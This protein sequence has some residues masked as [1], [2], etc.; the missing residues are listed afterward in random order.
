MKSPPPTVAKVKYVGRDVDAE[1][2]PEDDE[3]L[4]VDWNP[5]RRCDSGRGRSANAFQGAPG[6]SSTVSN[7]P[8]PSIRSLP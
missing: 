8:L 3:A 7:A 1:T 4:R 2:L 6:V 5:L